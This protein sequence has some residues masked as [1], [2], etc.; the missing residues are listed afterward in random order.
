MH[1]NPVGDIGTLITTI[2]K[3]QA[4]WHY[5]FTYVYAV[6]SDFVYLLQLQRKIFIFHN[7]K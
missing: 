6:C 7:R 2:N 4:S 1:K 5:F 3:K